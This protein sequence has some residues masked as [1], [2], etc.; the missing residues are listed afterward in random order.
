MY[1][2]ETNKAGER[3]HHSVYVSPAVVVNISLA[4]SDRFNNMALRLGGMRFLMI[5]IGCVGSLMAERGLVDILSISCRVHLV[6]PM[7]C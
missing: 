4:Q 1:N 3:A 2:R 5:F 7:I 6:V